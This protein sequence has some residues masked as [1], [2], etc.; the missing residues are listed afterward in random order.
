[1]TQEDKI[2]EL[3]KLA[4]AYKCALEYDNCPEATEADNILENLLDYG[5]DEL[6]TILNKYCGWSCGDIERSA[7]TVIEWL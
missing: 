3:K 6:V 4:V 2:K 5:K 1:M 7:F